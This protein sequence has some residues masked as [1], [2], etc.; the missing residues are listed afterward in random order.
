MSRFIKIV[1]RIRQRRLLG[2]KES[3]EVNFINT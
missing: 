2:L 3:V 1:S